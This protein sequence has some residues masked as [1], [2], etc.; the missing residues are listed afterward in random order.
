MSQ[1]FDRSICRVE[2]GAKL[3]FTAGLVV[4]DF[5]DEADRALLADGADDASRIP[6]P[7]PDASVFRLFQSLAIASSRNNASELTAG[8]TEVW[9]FLHQQLYVL[10]GDLNQACIGAQI[11]Y[12]EHRRASLTQSQ[13]H[14]RGHAEAI[15]GVGN[16]K[17]VICLA[18]GFQ[19]FCRGLSQVAGDIRAGR[20]RACRPGQPG[21]ATGGVEQGQ[22]L[23]HA[24]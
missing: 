2:E 14:R 13:A 7:S 5:I 11:N 6:K 17:P 9:V 8:S 10:A 22:N 1:I 12:A 19:S 23:R 15:I 20:M 4:P 3:I 16:F 24:R 21:R 18:Q